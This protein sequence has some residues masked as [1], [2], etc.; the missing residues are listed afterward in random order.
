MDALLRQSLLDG[1][2]PRIRERYRLQLDTMLAGLMT[3]PKGTT[4]TKPEGG[5]FIWV[6]LPE[7]YNT[8]S[9]LAQAVRQRV[10]YVPGTHFYVDGGHLNTLRLNF[11]NSTVS[12]IQQGMHVL[13]QVLAM[14]EG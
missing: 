9:L 12:Q 2:L 6:T 14:S 4:W 11:S 5:L 3:F 10:A 1:H 13:S 8:V 7:G